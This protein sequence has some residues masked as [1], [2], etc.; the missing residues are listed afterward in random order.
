MAEKKPASTTKKAAEPAPSKPDVVAP[1]GDP[2]EN[3]PDDVE[4]GKWTYDE[5]T[6][7]RR[8]VPDE[9]D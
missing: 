2:L 7:D 1:E 4:G 6:G 9:G 5:T 8:W 3:Y